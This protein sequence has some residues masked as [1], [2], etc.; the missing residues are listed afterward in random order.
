MANEKEFLDIFIRLK[1]EIQD[2]TKLS[3][4]FTLN[5]NVKVSGIE[6]LTKKIENLQKGVEIPIKLKLIDLKNSPIK[7]KSNSSFDDDNIFDSFLGPTT[8]SK[9]NIKSFTA[10]KVDQGSFKI[11]GQKAASSFGNAFETEFSK[12]MTKAVK[13]VKSALGGNIIKNATQ[14]SLD[15]FFDGPIIPKK[16]KNTGPKSVVGGSVQDRLNAQAF[17]SQSA[18]EAR[19][20]FIKDRA[21]QRRQ[22]DRFKERLRQARLGRFRESTNLEEAQREFD[23]SPTFLN[24]GSQR[25][26]IAFK[27]GLLPSD[28]RQTDRKFIDPRRLANK[29]TVREIGFAGLFGGLPGLAGAVAGG[30]VSPGGAFIGATIVEKLVQSLENAGEKIVGVFEN[31]SQAGLQFEQSILGISSSLQGAST[32][33]GPGGGSLSLKDQLSFQQDRAEGIQQSARSRLLPLGIGGAKESGI[34]GGI[35]SSLT[36][37][38]ITNFTPEDISEIAALIG[39][40]LQSQIPFLPANRARLETEDFFL[41]PSRNT[42]FNA[43][44]RAFTGDI[45][46]ASSV[47]EIKQALQGFKPVEDTLINS[48]TNASQ[49]FAQLDSKLNDIQTSAGREFLQA[50]IPAINEL[51]KSLS[52]PRLKDSLVSI[53]ALFGQIANNAIKLGNNIAKSVGGGV[54]DFAQKTRERGLGSNLLNKGISGLTENLISEDQVNGFFEN[55]PQVRDGLLRLF[56]FSPEV[57]EQSKGL[58][59]KGKKAKKAS[60]PGKT[61]SRASFLQ[62]QL[63]D[64]DKN[65]GINGEEAITRGFLASALSPLAAKEGV[66]PSFLRNNALAAAKL[67]VGGLEDIR[68]RRQGTF[69][70][71]LA[72]GQAG[73][74]SFNVRNLTLQAKEF[75]GIKKSREDELK[76]I[77]KQIAK[78]GD[79]DKQRALAD[80]LSKV[81]A[82]LNKNEEVLLQN[83][84]AQ[85]QAAKQLL[86]SLDTREAEINETFNPKTLTGQGQSLN[87]RDQKLEAERQILDNT[88][89][90]L[91]PKEFNRK[92]AALGIKTQQNKDDLETQGFTDAQ[93]FVGAKQALFDFNHIQIDL[94]AKLNGY[95]ESIISAQL[96]T[97]QASLAEYNTTQALEDFEAE[98]NLR[99]G[100]RQQQEIAAAESLISSTGDSGAANS[101]AIDTQ[102]VHGSSNFDATARQAFDR[103]QGIEQFNALKRKNDPFSVAEEENNQRATFE[104]SKEQAEQSKRSTLAGVDVANK[105]LSGFNLESASAK[106]DALKKLSDLKQITPAG[107]DASNELEKALS[108]TSTQDILKSSGF[109]DFGQFEETL[110]KQREVAPG[111]FDDLVKESQNLTPKAADQGLSNPLLTV[112]NS[113]LAEI[114]KITAKI[115]S[116]KDPRERPG[117][118]SIEA[119]KKGAKVFRTKEEIEAEDKAGGLKFN[120]DTGLFEDQLE[121]P[122]VPPTGTGTKTFVKD[123]NKLPSEIISEHAASVIGGLAD[124]S[125]KPDVFDETSGFSTGKKTFVSGDK[126]GA[127]ASGLSLNERASLASDVLGG[128]VGAGQVAP[129]DIIKNGLGGVNTSTLEGLGSTPKGQIKPGGEGGKNLSSGILAALLNIAQVTAQNS[130]EKM[131][132]GFKSAL[133]STFAGN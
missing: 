69:D 89:N 22:S 40:G 29:D 6:S 84:I 105:N 33:V 4:G 43:S 27:R 37:K 116:E 24:A 1:G 5:V 55:N 128:L 11:A 122:Y 26:D 85:S 71:S 124:G 102:L 94:N 121:K 95:K 74:A 21:D 35:I 93:T 17:P 68:Q 15:E 48:T 76:L 52:D 63:L 132:D 103:Q 53:A 99:S 19:S 44:T 39:A 51:T 111:Q 104:L 119:R 66:D 46:G 110:K 16:S 10:P 23:L 133:N 79:L 120:P 83:R 129:G 73:Q 25:K 101:L 58:F 59:G 3:K 13:N 41:Q 67:R 118:A 81:T 62:A 86:A 34:V 56:E 96:A 90:Q 114:R 60:L 123:L 2:L 97:K 64:P 70:T 92:K 14:G 8:G 130:P 113:I 80:K 98:I 65:Q 49:A 9:K 54:N 106:I 61:Q 77:E 108:S 36:Q 100:N 30:S 47:E 7:K 115:A 112:V 20:E 107:T 72:S 117:E 131:K 125:F 45:G 82:D 31:I 126:K 87:L 50:L 57:N 109:K 18:E 28:I 75:E 42:I 12:V 78:G 32:I 91:S 127:A 88:K 38:G